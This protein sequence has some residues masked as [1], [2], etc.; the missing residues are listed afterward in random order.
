MVKEGIDA[1]IA[2]DTGLFTGNTKFTY[3]IMRIR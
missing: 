1:Q 2:T 3:A